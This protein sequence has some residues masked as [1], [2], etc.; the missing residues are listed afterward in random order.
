MNITLPR[1]EGDAAS[2]GAATSPS[3]VERV[4]DG[5]SVHAILS[6]RLSLSCIDSMA[7]HDSEPPLESLDDLQAGIPLFG[8]TQADSLAQ[9][10]RHRQFVRDRQLDPIERCDVI[11]DDKRGL[12]G[13]VTSTAKVR[14]DKYGRPSP[15]VRMTAEHAEAIF[16]AV[17]KG[18]TREEVQKLAGACIIP[19]FEEDDE[20]RFVVVD[21]CGLF[22]QKAG[23]I[24]RLDLFKAAQKPDAFFSEFCRTPE[25]LHRFQV[26]L[27]S[28]ALKIVRLGSARSARFALPCYYEAPDYH[29]NSRA[30]ADDVKKANTI[31][32]TRSRGGGPYQPSFQSFYMFR[33]QAGEL[34]LLPR[35]KGYNYQFG[36]SY[37]AQHSGSVFLQWEPLRMCAAISGRYIF[38][39]GPHIEAELL[40]VGKSEDN[41]P[42][43]QEDARK[44]TQQLKRLVDGGFCN[45]EAERRKVWELAQKGQLEYVALVTG[46]TGSEPRTFVGEHYD[47]FSLVGGQ[48]RLVWDKG[49]IDALRR[50]M[51]DDQREFAEA[52]GF[53]KVILPLDCPQAL[54]QEDAKMQRNLLESGKAFPTVEDARDFLHAKFAREDIDIGNLNE[55]N[56]AEVCSAATVFMDD[57]E[58]V[59]EAHE[60]L[61]AAVEVEYRERLQKEWKWVENRWETEK[62]NDAEQKAKRSKNKKKRQ[63]ADAE[64]VAKEERREECVAKIKAVLRS[65]SEKVFKWRHMQGALNN[66]DKRGVLP[67][68][69]SVMRGS[70]LKVI[71]DV[72]AF[73][74][75]KPHGSRKDLVCKVRSFEK[76]LCASGGGSAGS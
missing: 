47:C 60:R 67:I 62:V 59:L 54:T 14:V 20:D 40:P 23:A 35:T 5:E 64:K 1:A 25:I 37:S 29:D 39:D 74:V 15:G 17:S 52:E 71:S 30:T 69:R 6:Q 48:S 50:G 28:L 42:D 72:G 11:V 27:R 70:K 44:R 68:V 73:M 32:A 61:R 46:F 53:V 31:I 45:T 9:F 66:L 16:L 18:E 51:P 13:K 26:A 4:E 49:T 76:Q 36:G 56:V 63:A 41:D 12:V 58:A 33:N 2:A 65:T 7:E 24:L 22:L 34:H 3:T 43:S 38:C 75:N 10:V 21:F 19:D 8:K 55:E 57:D